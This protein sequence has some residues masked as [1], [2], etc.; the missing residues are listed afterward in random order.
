MERENFY[1]LLDL[2]I[3]PPETDQKTIDSAI[4]KKQAEWSRLR[5]HPSRGLQFQKYITL[6]P[7][8]RRIMSDPK[9][10][11]EE[12]KASLDLKDQ[13]KQNKYTEID[14]HIDILMG[15]GFI[16]R[17]EVIKLA[18]V[19][20]M[21]ESEIQSRV[22][23]KKENKFAKFDQQISLRVAKGYVTETEIERLARRLG[24][25][26][27]E[28]RPRIHCP[29]LKNEKET[30]E[31]PRE[32]DRSIEKAIRENLR[33]IGKT[34]LYDFLG[35]PE[36][37][38]LEKLQA[39][40]IAKKQELNAVGKKDA[41]LTA[42]NILAGH[43]VT[44]FK[45][46]ESRI[47]YDVS[48]AKSKL[49]QLDADID[50]CGMSGRIVPEYFDI[51]VKKAMDFGME[52]DEAVNYIR[53]YCK[54]KNLGLVLPRR[55]KQN[56]VLT[57]VLAAILVI[58][59]VSS[60]I[61]YYREHQSKIRKAEFTALV[62]KAEA[63]K[64]PDASIRVFTGYIEKHRDHKAYDKFIADAEN[65]VKVIRV[66]AGERG[67]S[68][69]MAHVGEL[70]KAGNLP[71]ARSALADYLKTSPP[72]DFTRKASAELAGIEKQ[73][74]INDFES[75]SRVMIEGQ[76]D[77]KIEAI[78]RYTATHPKS[79]HAGLVEQ[80]LK[81]LAN[82]YYIFAQNALDALEKE[83]KWEE[84]AALAQ[85]YIK[86][87]DNSHSD[88]L[89]QR[90]EVYETRIREDQTFM[91]L[92]QKAEAFGE[93]YQQGIKLLRDYLAAYP[94]AAF[95]N[96]IQE[97]IGRL[98]QLSRVRDVSIAENRMRT[99]L[100]K[101]GGRFS[102]KT[103]GVIADSRTGLMWTLIDSSVAVPGKCLNYDEAKKYADALESGG[104]KDWRLPTPG[105]LADLYNQGPSFPAIDER[106]YWSSTSYSGYSEGWY[107]IVETLSNTPKSGIVRKD[108][109]E[110]G[111]VRAVRGK[112]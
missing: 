86:I 25:V 77:A 87:Y 28:V 91:A 48:L 80:M 22:N 42:G 68:A 31:T 76:T 112:H 56:Y 52:K 18:Q 47:S 71:S 14:H 61:F 108:S 7:E 13:D 65:R 24:L 63:E 110:C 82:E 103:G 5:N 16:T 50:I 81:E 2:S 95:E 32:F 58:A 69:V 104:Y 74:E 83:K 49:A 10:R 98:E 109:M 96:S 101:T 11:A 75:V 44:I 19:H 99:L 93:N 41:D 88:Q 54:R 73:I 29:I 4:I 15:K 72:A 57:G 111:T 94:G 34:S 59:A 36:S 51:L 89:R 66:R 90:L 92:K 70:T 45:S 6:I 100:G 105:E 84:C 1:I 12:L 38:E 97:E 30:G 55:K 60:G 33:I 20:E 23:S 37:T 106:W 40:A 26:P 64:T 46:E 62:K 9:L 67:F 85:S 39:S 79:P 17:D 102:E 8:I 3:D 107:T 21:Q 53:N 27:D 78:H 35:L 43:C